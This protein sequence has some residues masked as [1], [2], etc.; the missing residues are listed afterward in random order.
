MAYLCS[1]CGQLHT[2]LPDLGFRSPSAASSVPQSEWPDRVRA[3]DDLCVVDSEAYFIRGVLELPVLDHDERFGIG[4]WVS[5]KPDNFWQYAEHFDDDGDLAP[6]FGWLSNDFVFQG[7][8]SLNLKTT[9][10]FQGD[11]SRPQIVL[12][13]ADHPLVVAQQNGVTLDEVWAF[14]H[15]HLD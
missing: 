1:S 6:T 4:A 11:G 14:L 12:H 10:H 5:Q 8:S 3:S 2:E 7:V 13:K 9:V 15:Q